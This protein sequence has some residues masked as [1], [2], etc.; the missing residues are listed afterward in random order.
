M[1]YLHQLPVLLACFTPQVNKNSIYWRAKVRHPPFLGTAL[2]SFLEDISLQTSGCLLPSY[3]SATSGF[4]LPYR[5]LT[6]YHSLTRDQ[7]LPHQ[8]PT[9]TS[10]ETNH[11]LTNHQPHY[12]TTES[13]LQPCSPTSCLSLSRRKPQWAIISCTALDLNL[14]QTNLT[15][16]ASF[17]LHIISKFD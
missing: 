3:W 15:Q 7:P 9:T 4:T 8:R 1:W 17:Y 2:Y 12:L 6:P 5:L 11:Y 16:L 10:P 14:L 13:A